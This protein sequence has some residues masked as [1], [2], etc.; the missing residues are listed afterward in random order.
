[1]FFGKEQVQRVRLLA[2]NEVDALGDKDIDLP[3]ENRKIDTV[4]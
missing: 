2:K 1:M 4:G 3:S